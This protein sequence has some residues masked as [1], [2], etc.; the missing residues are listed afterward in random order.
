MHPGPPLTPE[1]WLR[2][3]FLSKSVAQGQM[4]RHKKRDI[5]RYV[6]MPAFLDEMNRRGF[7]TVENRGQMGIFC[8]RE[9]IR[10]LI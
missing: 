7:R 6:G 8:N 4:L 2:D 3:L 9:S 10:R 5:E 1:V